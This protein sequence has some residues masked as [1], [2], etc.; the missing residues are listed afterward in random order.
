MPKNQ[1][2]DDVWPRMAKEPAAWTQSPDGY[3]RS[4]RPLAGPLRLGTAPG[5]GP[6]GMIKGGG[7]GSDFGMDRVT[8]LGF[9]PAGTS[10]AR[11]ARQESSTRVSQEIRRRPG[12]KTKDADG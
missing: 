10:N 9:D 4:D 8:P 12:Q 2:P 1:G 7:F 11:S 3:L 6:K 5:V